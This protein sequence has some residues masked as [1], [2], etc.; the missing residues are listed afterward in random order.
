MAKSFQRAETVICAIRVATGADVLTQPAT[1][2]TITITNPVGTAVNTATAMT[3][4][5][6]PVVVDGVTCNYHYDYQPASDAVL[7][8]YTV[9]Y[10]ATDGTRITN[11]RDYFILE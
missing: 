9:L 8:K 4:D 5:A 10:T 2:M 6:V 11:L 3:Y 1:S 7:G